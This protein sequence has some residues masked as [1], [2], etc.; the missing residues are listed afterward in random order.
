MKSLFIV[1]LKLFISF[2]GV[3]VYV[4]GTD[5]GMNSILKHMLVFALVIAPWSFK[6]NKSDSK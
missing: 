6:S 1:L 4:I 3:M 5:M 2:I